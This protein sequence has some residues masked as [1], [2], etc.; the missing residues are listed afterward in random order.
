MC[1]NGTA[2]GTVLVALIRKLSYILGNSR[3]LVHATACITSYFVG[4]RPKS[5]ITYV[6]CEDPGVN[7]GIMSVSNTF[8]YNPG[9]PTSCVNRNPGLNRTFPRPRHRT[10]SSLRLERNAILV[11]VVL[12][13]PSKDEVILLTVRHGEQPIF[14]I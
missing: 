9:V 7:W 13:H 3:F 2:C 14:Y 10:L 8:L 4:R 11:R 1:E 6:G 12:V 5:G